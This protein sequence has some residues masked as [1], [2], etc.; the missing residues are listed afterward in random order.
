MPLVRLTDGSNTKLRIPDGVDVDAAVKQYYS[1]QRKAKFETP[2]FKQKVADQQAADRE[3]YDPSKGMSWLDRQ[4]AG[5]ASGVME[6]PRGLSNM[7]G[8]SSDEDTSAAAQLDAPIK[9]AAPVANFLGNTAALMAATAPLGGALGLTTRALGAS[10]GV[11]ASLASG[12]GNVMAQGALG[13]AINAA[14][15]ERGQGA[16]VGA[17]LGGGSYGILKGLG[18]VLSGAGTLRP[19]MAALRNEM[20]TDLHV[21]VGKSAAKGSLL[22]RVGDIM[23][24]FPGSRPQIASQTANA[25]GQFAD[26]VASKLTPPKEI[27]GDLSTT[28]RG[29]RVAHIQEIQNVIDDIQKPIKEASFVIGGKEWN[30]SIEAGLNG[31]KQPELR[32][33]ARDIIKQSYASFAN[34]EGAPEEVTGTYVLD[35]LKKIKSL[36]FEK[37]G[38]L[39]TEGQAVNS[40]VNAIKSWGSRTLKGT[41]PELL[42]NWNKTVAIQNKHWGNFERLKRVV[43]QWGEGSVE[44]LP[45]LFHKEFKTGTTVGA[46]GLHPLEKQINLGMEVFGD[47]GLSSAYKTNLGLGLVGGTGALAGAGAMAGGLPGTVATGTLLYVAAKIAGKEGVQRFLAGDKAFQATVRKTLAQNPNLIK[48]TSLPL[49][50]AMM[51][52]GN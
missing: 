6:I 3:E 44:E 22:N 23:E 1:D 51:P 18:K 28:L 49:T 10:G 15:G 32:E 4:G 42:D 30:Q 12:A 48:N 21:P 50:M 31:I 46:L 45:K 41:K 13:G 20:G 52:Q 47:P 27:I 19:E 34:K 17:A 25:A 24:I 36:K 26:D 38:D 33:A 43:D 39:G 40:I 16:L 9:K 8:L 35:L 7:V 5:L 11:G 14:P 37:G 2:E 29:D